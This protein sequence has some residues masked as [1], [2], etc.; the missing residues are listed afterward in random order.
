MIR[1]ACRKVTVKLEVADYPAAA[2][3]VG[4][5]VML[6][7]VRRTVKL[8]VARSGN[9]LPRNPVVGATKTSGNRR[10]GQRGERVIGPGT[11]GRSMGGGCFSCG[12]RS[13]EWWLCPSRSRMSVVSLG[14]SVGGRRCF[15]SVGWGMLRPSAMVSPYQV[16]D[17]MGGP[18]LGWELG[19]V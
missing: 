14:L 13:Y 17:W 2:K 8:A 9:A 15:D 3:P 4:S 1:R 7:A 10:G 18:P 16:L 11:G 19:L 5:G 12:D 6:A